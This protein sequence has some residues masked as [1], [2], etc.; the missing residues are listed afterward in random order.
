MEIF[1][2]SKSLVENLSYLSAPIVAILGFAAIVQLRLTKKAI[3]VTSQRQAAE[4]AT[5]QIE[6]YT[7]NIIPLENKLSRIRNGENFKELNI[8]DS[9]EFTIQELKTKIDLKTINERSDENIRNMESILDIL[10]AIETFSTY[11]SKGVADE[12][13]A[14]SSLGVTFCSS[15]QEY[16]Y[17]LSI[18]RDEDDGNA[19]DNLVAL[20][21]IWNSR[22]KSEKI[23][24]ELIRKKL[25][26]KELQI[27][28]VDILGT[29]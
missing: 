13:I 24:R 21:K 14:Y 4:L 18:L 1:D 28:K 8:I 2:Q 3:V 11:F 19:F 15:V 20:Y 7:K 17:E 6:V 10:N 23:N 5:Q 27:P 16:T 26:L 29:K 25:Q 22:M 9:K 12:E